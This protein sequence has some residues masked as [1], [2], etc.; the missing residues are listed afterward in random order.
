ME[1]LA[2][3]RQNGQKIEANDVYEKVS[4]VGAS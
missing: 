4:V 2:L 1:L 3:F